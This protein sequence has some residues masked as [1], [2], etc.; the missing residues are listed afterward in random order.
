MMKSGGTSI[1]GSGDK[2]VVE[3]GNCN[4]PSTKHQSEICS[5]L[6]K[7]FNPQI[8]HIKSTCNPHNPHLTHNELWIKCRFISSPHF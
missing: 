3:D 6:K 4:F 1:I 5:P 2:A 8:I 7:N